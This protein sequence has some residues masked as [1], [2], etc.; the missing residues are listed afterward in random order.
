[1][2]LSGSLGGEFVPKLFHFSSWSL[3]VPEPDNT[4]HKGSTGY[5]IHGG[6]AFLCHLSS[7][8][9]SNEDTYLL[10]GFFFVSYLPKTLP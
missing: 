10:W 3:W 9:L 6:E 2:V 7:Q 5:L 4:W 8:W 1:M